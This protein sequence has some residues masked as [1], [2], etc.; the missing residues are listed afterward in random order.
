MLIPLRIAERIFVTLSVA[1]QE[2]ERRTDYPTE[3]LHLI[4]HKYEKDRNEYLGKKGWLPSQIRLVTDTETEALQEWL[5]ER[6]EQ[7]EE[8]KRHLAEW[9]RE[10]E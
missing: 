2:I 9:E 1:V 8:T 6:A 3:S 5:D 10:F 4:L 7:S